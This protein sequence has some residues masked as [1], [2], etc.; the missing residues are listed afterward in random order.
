MGGQKFMRADIVI[1]GAGIA[2]AATAYHLRR[3]SGARILLL[4]KESSP[5]Q[6]STARNAAMIR[7]KIPDP[8]TQALAREGAEALRN[9]E[10][11][12]FRH[13]GSV[14]IGWG[15]DDAASRCALASGKGL[16]CPDD[17]VVDPAGLLQSYLR[18]Q[19]VLCD[20]LVRGWTPAGRGATVHTSRGDIAAGL[21][22][23]AAGPWAGTL[24]GIAVQPRNRHLYLTPAMAEVDPQWPFVWDVVHGLYFRPDSGGL[25]LCACD[26]SEREPGDYRID[27]AVQE[28]LAE[29]LATHQPALAD[30]AVKMSWT[31]Q[32]VFA[33]DRRFVVG[34]D[35][36]HPQLFHVAALGGHGM[37]TSYAVGRIAAEAIMAGADRRDNP[38][39]AARVATQE[40]AATQSDVA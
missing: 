8:A 10:L 12:D 2:G 5:G 7:E 4:E 40:Q 9:G 26:E 17:G 27:H 25:L 39:N 20:T 30:I 11:C 15:A 13:T 35:P 32:R 1:V 16:W 6:H 22:I 28:R 14:L 21:V 34:F 3:L 36:R 38:F 33:A 18:G 19:T 23:N 24:G 31:G 29:L 37:T